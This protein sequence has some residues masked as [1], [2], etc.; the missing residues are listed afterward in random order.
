MGYFTVSGLDMPVSGE[1]RISGA[2]NAALPEL[3]AAVLCEGAALDN[4][5]RLSD[6]ETAA[7]ILENAG[8]SFERAGGCVSVLPREN[9]N[10]CVPEELC[11]KM[12]SSILFLA[13]LLCRCGEAAVY[14]PGGCCL[15]ARPVDLH[16]YVLETLGA[17]I[18]ADNCKITASAPNGLNGA[19]ID[20][21]IPSVGATETAVMAAA[22]ASG[23]SVIKNPAMEPEIEDLCRFLNSA[24]ADTVFG[25]EIKIRGKNGLLERAQHSVMPDR[26][27]AGTY[28]AAAA[29][30]GGELYLKNAEQRHILPFIKILENMG[31]IIK[32]RSQSIYI[33]APGCLYSPGLVETAPYPEFPTDLQ[34][35]LTALLAVKRGKCTVRENIFESRLGHIPQLR[36]M[37]ADIEIH[38]ERT[39]TVRGLDGPLK[40]ESV[41]ATDLRCGAALILAGLA[42]KNG[43][44]VEGGEYILRGYED[45]CKKMSLIGIKIKYST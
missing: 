2:K 7:K 29:I 16:I 24:G 11:G 17:K 25:R 22:C 5:P 21:P 40:S 37:G 9:Q 13:P 36:K 42:A 4:C 34:P 35:Q 20:L 26:I 27:E 10:G 33:D 44:R 43:N 15:G 12:R 30:T 6:I 23:E 39:F 38:D 45:I 32:S 19:E 8:F 18:S 3:A 1:V 28:L 14:M 41:R 31:C